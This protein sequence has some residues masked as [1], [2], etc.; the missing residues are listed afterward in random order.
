MHPGILPC[1]QIVWGCQNTKLR[2]R[3]SF[4]ISAGFKTLRSDGQSIRVTRQGRL[5]ALGQYGNGRRAGQPATMVGDLPCRNAADRMDQ[6]R[7][8][9][10]RQPGGSLQGSRI[11]LDLGRLRIIGIFAAAILFGLRRHHEMLGNR[12]DIR[13]SGFNTTRGTAHGDLDRRRRVGGQSAIA[14]HGEEQQRETG[15][16]PRENVTRAMIAVLLRWTA[17]TASLM[18]MKL[19]ILPNRRSPWMERARGT[20]SVGPIVAVPA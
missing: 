13:G 8:R 1:H 3:L 7:R 6:G 20:P 5:E 11:H 2:S 14:S 9:P 16:A 18:I 10:L 17:Q 19:I 15:C 4:P 12:P